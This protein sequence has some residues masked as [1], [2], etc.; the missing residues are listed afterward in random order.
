VN[1]LRPV[2]RRPPVSHGAYFPFPDRPWLAR[3]ASLPHRGV[4]CIVCGFGIV[5]CDDPA[6]EAA[7]HDEACPHA[8]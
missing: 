1:D 8:G 4:W 5:V 2:P 6:E 7:E 3:D